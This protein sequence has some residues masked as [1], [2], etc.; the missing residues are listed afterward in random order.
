ME[1]STNGYTY[2]FKPNTVQFKE[3]YFD[4]SWFVAKMNPQN[5]DEWE[6]TKILSNI[7]Y[8]MTKLGCKYHPKIEKQ[9]KQVISL[10]NDNSI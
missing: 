6:T 3:E 7:W 2:Y 8:A 4:K 9:I 1:I 10:V 5:E